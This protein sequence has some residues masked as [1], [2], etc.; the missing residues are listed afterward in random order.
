M[1]NVFVVSSPCLASGRSSSL[2]RSSWMGARFRTGVPTS[3]LTSVASPTM[4][5][6]DIWYETVGPGERLTQG[7]IIF[8]CPLVSWSS[9]PIQVTGSGSEVEALKQETSA[10][11]AVG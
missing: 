1:P 4:S 9:T 5:M 3:C 8:D 7:D 11:H 10:S 2:M 6:S